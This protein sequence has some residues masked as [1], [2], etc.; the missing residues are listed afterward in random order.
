MARTMLVAQQP[1][2]G[3][4]NPVY[5]AANA[6]GHALYLDRH[7]VLEVVNGS[8]GSVTVTFVTPGT[9]DAGS[10]PD[11]A[12]A[13]PAGERRKF[14]FANALSLYKQADGT[15]HVDFSAVTSVTV[16]LFQT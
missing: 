3:G 5:S 7:S 6:D 15:I 8:G 12:V 1:T 13:I 9:T 4:L 14:N 16:G 2:S 11:K 10:I